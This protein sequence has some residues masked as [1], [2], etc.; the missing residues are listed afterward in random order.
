MTFIMKYAVMGF[1]K[2]TIWTDDLNQN[3]HIYK[4]KPGLGELRVNHV[5]INTI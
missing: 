3:P 4:S 5:V 1:I 2:N